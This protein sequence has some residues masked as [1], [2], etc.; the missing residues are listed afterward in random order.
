MSLFHISDKLNHLSQRRYTN[1]GVARILE[2]YNF[3]TRN[4]YLRVIKGHKV[5]N[6]YVLKRIRMF[7]ESI[8]M[9]YKQE[10]LPGERIR[11]QIWVDPRIEIGMQNRRR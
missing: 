1:K 3:Y 10:F 9:Q 7:Q 6:V 2:N 4:F 8:G 5:L 11:N